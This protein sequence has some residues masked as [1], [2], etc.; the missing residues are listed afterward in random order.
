[1]TDEQ[2]AELKRLNASIE[3]APESYWTFN[4]RAHFFVREN[5]DVALALTDLKEALRN[6]HRQA[7][8]S[9][10]A[11]LRRWPSFLIHRGREAWKSS[12]TKQNEFIP[13]DLQS[14]KRFQELKAVAAFELALEATHRLKRWRTTRPTNWS[15]LG[16]LELVSSFDKWEEI[17]DWENANVEDCEAWAIAVA[18]GRGFVNAASAF[19]WAILMKLGESFSATPSATLAHKARNRELEDYKQLAWWKVTILREERGQS[20]EY[21]P[22]LAKY[23][24]ERARWFRRHDAYTEARKD[25]S[26]A[27]NIAP[28]DPRGY[29]ARAKAITKLKWWSPK[30]GAAGDYGR[31]I[32]LR[33]AAGQIAETPENLVAQAEQLGP[34]LKKRKRKR[35]HARAIA[36]YGLA[37]YAQPGTPNYYCARAQ[38]ILALPSSSPHWHYELTEA[39]ERGVYVCY[40]NALKFAPSL[41]EAYDSVVQYLTKTL[42]RD[43]AHQ[44]IEALMETRQELLEFGLDAELIG[45]ILAEVERA[46]AN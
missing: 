38:I 18:I 31:A 46:L 5:F 7:Y 10:R 39:E 26:H 22:L 41:E 35:A 37:S 23:L 21:S 19:K 33:M 6:E 13:A 1:M 20:E 36:F 30:E 11:E 3:A 16:S 27:I 42:R 15:S 8:I 4:E 12:R 40:L 28:N 2:H 9:T 24:I 43:T 45:R 34:A 29:E 25:F 44:R 14:H 32:R 17:L